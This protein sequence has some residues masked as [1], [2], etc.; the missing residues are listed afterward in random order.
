MPAI[1]VRD[2]Q[3]KDDDSCM[4]SDLVAGTHG[5]GFWILDNVTP[6]RQAADAAAASSAHLFKPATG[7]RI[8]F[9]TNDPTPWPPEWPAGEN[10]APGA[11]V[12][13]YLPATASEAKLEFLDKQGQVLRAYS[14]KDA[15]RNPDPATDPEAYNKMCQQRPNAPDCGLPL[16]WPAPQQVLKTT[17]GMHRFSW[18][19]HYDATP[20]TR[21]GR[22]ESVAVPH[23][24]YPGPG[25]PWVAPG[26]YTVRLTVD[27]K[28]LTQP[29]AVKLDP[30]VKVT[31]EVQQLFALT[32]QAEDH[33][34][35]AAKAYK[36]ARAMIAQTN[37]AARKKKLEEIAPV[38]APAAAGG[39]EFAGFG[40][41]PPL[42]PAT[43][44]NVASQLVGAV[45][46]M[47]AS[48][49]APTEA[50]LAAFKAADAAYAALMTKW[51]GLRTASN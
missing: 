26:V 38:E 27:G 24:T 29:I 15:V 2:I 4:C 16:Y 46:P 7:I 6:L 19:L 35:I 40:P 48:E 21:G 42:P 41:P 23:R 3:V 43:L 20:G 13:Y 50:Q 14:S 17:A 22:G 49:M 51:S 33:A 11:M 28:V 31:P 37:D 5:R 32:A 45:M 10:P 47:Q 39:G 12:D 18:D 36:D 30:R 25:A 9:G 8:R 34:R 1:S 44:A